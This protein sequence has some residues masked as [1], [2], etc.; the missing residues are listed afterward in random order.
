M[1]AVGGMPA[2]MGTSPWCYAY[3]RGRLLKTVDERHELIEHAGC[4]GR[5]SAVLPAHT[6][7]TRAPEV[8]GEAIP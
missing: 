8:E 1:S 5:R 6:V 4:P 3:T 7:C 2:T